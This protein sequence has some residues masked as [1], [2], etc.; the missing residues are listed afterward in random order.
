[1]WQQL[2][3]LLQRAQ[4][5]SAVRVLL[6]QGAAG[7]FCAGADVAELLRCAEDSQWVT[8]NQRCIAQ[9]QL[10][11]E[12]L[13]LPTLALIDGA[14]FGG[15]LGLALCCDFRLATPASRFAITPARLG[16]AYSLADT[17]RLHRTVGASLCRQMLLTAAELDAEQ[18]LQAGLT[19]ALVAP[20]RMQAELSDRIRRLTALSP[21]SQQAIKRTIRTLEGGREDSAASLHALMLAG[22]AGPDMA[23]GAAAFL[24]KRKPQFKR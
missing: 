6:V 23:E 11:L 16:L 13:P 4:Q 22:F 5:D 19:D 7:A 24:Q 20:E 21:W 15:G 10:V 2:P 17:G 18:A 1:M 12:T 8:E 9:A 3:S 14:C